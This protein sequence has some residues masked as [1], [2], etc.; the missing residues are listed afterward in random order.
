MGSN[1]SGLEIFLQRKVNVG[2]FS[3]LHGYLGGVA[4]IHTHQLNVFGI[5]KRRHLVII[6]DGAQNVSPWLNLKALLAQ[7]IAVGGFDRLFAVDVE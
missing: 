3:F 2:S 7:V 4:F 6:F 5:I 1:G